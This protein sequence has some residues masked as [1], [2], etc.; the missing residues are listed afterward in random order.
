MLPTRTIAIC[1]Q[2]HRILVLRRRLGQLEA[3]D[4]ALLVDTIPNRKGPCGKRMGPG[5][6][7][8]SLRVGK[9]ALGQLLENIVTRSRDI[10]IMA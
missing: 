5:Q 9:T 2:T 6:H 8:A 4:L 1:V 3:L 10:T 7:C